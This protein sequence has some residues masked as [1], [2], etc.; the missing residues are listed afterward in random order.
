MLAG[1]MTAAADIPSDLWEYTTGTTEDEDIF[2]SFKEV[3]LLIPADWAGRCGLSVDEDKVTFYHLD[4]HEAWEKEGNAYGGNLFTL[5]Y[6]QNYDFMNTEPNYF[7]IG[8]GEEGIYYIALPSDVRGYTKD[9]AIMSEWTQLCDDLQWIKE[10]AYVTHPGEGIVTAENISSSVGNLTED[11]YILPD[12]S[13]RLIAASELH[14]MNANQLQMAINEIYA[15]HNRRFV[16]PDIQAYFDAQ[17]WYSGTIEASRFDPATL[18]QTEWSN[19]STMLSCMNQSPSGQTV[20]GTVNVSGPASPHSQILD[21]GADIQILSGSDAAPQAPI[22]ST[23]AAPAANV[24]YTTAGV[25]MR[26]QAVSGSTIIA[27]VMENVGVTVTGDT[28]NGWVPV[29][30]GGYSGYIYQDYL[31]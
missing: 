4:S 22:V 28:V 24:R 30:A 13:T 17:S 9:E 11:G 2:F 6:S 27:V 21:G 3:E 25:N 15:R 16:T 20:S 7:V 10:N 31:K 1:A 18:S 8:S 29:S 19:I 14:G 23:S 26:S 5:V 12:S